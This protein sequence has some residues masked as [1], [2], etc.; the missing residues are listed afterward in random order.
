MASR[1][2][3]PNTN[4]QRDGDEEED[5]EAGGSAGPR[6][7]AGQGQGAGGG[8]MDVETSG[9]GLSHGYVPSNTL[10][11]SI[12]TSELR[13]TF[14]L[15]VST[16]P[17]QGRQTSG[18]LSPGRG[19][20]EQQGQGRAFG[21]TRDDARGGSAFQAGKKRPSVIEWESSQAAGAGTSV[22]PN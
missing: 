18:H 4:Q 21:P 8:A 2:N 1:E 12:V 15:G 11:D 22:R 9:T 17:G 10:G 7:G 5:N 14:S 13:V 16:R 3:L 19:G 20:R 6:D